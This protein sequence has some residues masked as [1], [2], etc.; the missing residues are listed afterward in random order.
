MTFQKKVMHDWHVR[1]RYCGPQREF[2]PAH[3]SAGDMFVNLQLSDGRQT[4]LLIRAMGQHAA[5]VDELFGNFRH[6]AMSTGSI[7]FSFDVSTNL[8]ANRTFN[9]SFQRRSVE[10]PDDGT[11]PNRSVGLCLTHRVRRKSGGRTQPIIRLSSTGVLFRKQQYRLK[12]RSPAASCSVHSNPM[13]ARTS[14]LLT[15]CHKTSK[16][17]SVRSTA[18]VEDSAGKDIDSERLFTNLRISG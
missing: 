3:H 5:F 16:S 17:H 15:L 18:T 10:N 11:F 13:G 1:R 4:L 9:V 8:G 6:R 14:P 12:A 2:L 7:Q